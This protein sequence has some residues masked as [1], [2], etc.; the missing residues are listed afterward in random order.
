[1]VGRRKK[2]NQHINS[3]GINIILAEYS[4]LSAIRFKCRGHI[5]KQN[6]TKQKH[7]HKTH[8]KRKPDRK[9][10][11]DESLKHLATMYP[12][13]QYTLIIDPTGLCGNR[14]MTENNMS[15]VFLYFFS[16]TKVACTYS[17]SSL[18]I[19]MLCL[20]YIIVLHY[21]AILPISWQKFPN[22]A[23]FAC[24]PWCILY[25]TVSLPDPT[26]GLHLCNTRSFLSVAD[27][28]IRCSHCIRPN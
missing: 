27:A 20:I 14:H 11:N 1:M 17:W 26:M 9:T 28:C 22:I 23:V 8:T 15:E 24:I 7:T 21:G 18:I 12:S 16:C 10:N 25:E 19:M 13:K 3:R 2:G 4:S 5:E 6:K